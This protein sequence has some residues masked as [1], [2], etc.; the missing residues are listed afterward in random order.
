MALWSQKLYIIVPL[1][2]IILGHWSLI[3]QGVLLKAE[4]VPG[5]GCVITHTNNT[6]LSAVFIYSMCFDLVVLVLTA[7]KLAFPRG[8]RSQLMNLLFR[9]GL[10]YFMIAYVLLSLF[11]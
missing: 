1:V 8:Q 7:A 2:L 5:T 3:L 4:W 9:D 11:P 6:V 10:I